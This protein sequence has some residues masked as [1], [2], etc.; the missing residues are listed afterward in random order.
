MLNY[1]EISPIALKIGFF[2]IHWYGIMYL[3]GFVGGWG[4]LQ[5]RI[6]HFKL[7]WTSDDLGDLV[8]YIVLGV[9]LGGRLGYVLFYNLPFYLTHPAQI[10]ATWDG[11]MAFHGGLIGVAIA[12]A[13]YGR[14]YGRQF[15]EIADFVIPV[16]PIGLGTGAHRQLYQRRTVGQNCG[17]SLGIQIALR[18]CPLFTLLQQHYRLAIVSL[19][20]PHSFTNVYWRE[21][22][23][24]WCCGAFL[25]NLDPEWRSQDCLPYCMEFFDSGLSLFGYRMPS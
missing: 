19:G 7:N 15:F 8:I 22:S 14:R 12:I 25:V 24:F 3:V 23:C 2:A 20:I 1:P 10:L 16:V 6:R 13:I 17:S 4:L 9:V 11:G 21:S 5:Y 18:R